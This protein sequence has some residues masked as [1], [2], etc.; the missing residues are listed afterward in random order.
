MHTSTTQSLTM[1]RE[2]LTATLGTI[3][4]FR[5]AVSGP[6][7][8]LTSNP[9]FS[10]RTKGSTI[11]PD[12]CSDTHSVRR[13]YNCSSA[14]TCGVD[15]GY[16]LSLRSTGCHNITLSGVRKDIADRQGLYVHECVGKLLMT[17]LIAKDVLVSPGSEPDDAVS[18]VLLA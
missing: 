8:G 10:G 11:H 18:L 6:T 4:A 14:I 1:L 16:E 9:V 5:Q 3:Q 7:A 17:R 12:A 15:L 13:G 2:A